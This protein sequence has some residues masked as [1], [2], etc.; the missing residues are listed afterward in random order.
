VVREAFASWGHH[1]QNQLATRF[2]LLIPMK[3]KLPATAL[4]VRQPW[5]EL[6]VR[7]LKTEEFRSSLTH[8]RGEVLIYAARAFDMDEWVRATRDRFYAS[9][10]KRM[11]PDDLPFGQ[12]V[13][14]VRIIDC[15]PR[16][17]RG[18]VWHLGGACRFGRPFGFIGRVQPR[19]WKVHK[20][21]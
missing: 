15:A 13:G 10:L 14:S 8:H 9:R 2:N 4:S 5:A 7:G 6:I 19:F 18:W 3:I 1:I 21:V 11:Q 20:L 16:G 12:I 17:T